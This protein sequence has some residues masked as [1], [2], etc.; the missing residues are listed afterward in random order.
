[1][2]ADLPLASS[3]A[4]PAPVETAACAP[5]FSHRQCWTAPRRQAS[6]LDP[7]PGNLAQTGRPGAA[8]PAKTLYHLDRPSRCARPIRD[9]E[10]RYGITATPPNV[11][12]LLWR[13]SPVVALHLHLR[14]GF[15]AIR[16]LRS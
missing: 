15:R 13:R 10:L 2:A 14:I 8:S 12:C 16:R 11:A 5:P 3:Q 6:P 9:S 1:M 7:A 4:F